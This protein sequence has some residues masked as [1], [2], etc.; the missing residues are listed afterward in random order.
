MLGWWLAAAAPSSVSSNVWMNSHSFLETLETLRRDI[1]SVCMFSRTPPGLAN[2][3]SSFK[4]TISGNLRRNSTWTTH[5]F[6]FSRV[7]F[8]SKYGCS[9]SNAVPAESVSRAPDITDLCQGSLL[10]IDRVFAYD[11]HRPHNTR[12]L[13]VCVIEERHVSFEHCAHV[14]ACYR[15]FQS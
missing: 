4:E 5:H 14:I 2:L 9:G 8:S 12:F 1:L 7:D 10:T 13:A 6:G 3:W 11:L 15:A